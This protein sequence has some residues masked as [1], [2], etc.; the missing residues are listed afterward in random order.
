MKSFN[1]SLRLFST[2]FVSLLFAILANAQGPSQNLEGDVFLRTL[3]WGVSQSNLFYRDDGDYRPLA[4]SEGSLSGYH[5]YSGSR[6]FKVFRKVT[7]AETGADRYL[8]FLET[9]LVAGASQQIL[10]F[11]QSPTD[12]D[13]V[14][15]FAYDDSIE[16][17]G[18][19]A[20]FIGNFSPLDLAFQINDEERFGLKPGQSRIIEHNGDMHAVVQIAAYRGDQWEVEYRSSP[21]LWKGY[22]NYFF[23]RDMKGRSNVVNGIAPIILKE[24]VARARKAL[25]APDG[26]SETG[27]IEGRTVPFDPE[28]GF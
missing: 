1:P 26:A 5:P 15:V 22:R 16:H 12:R 6:N 18:E 17:M 20:V 9:T 14:R 11:F 3:G 21:R 28:A 24:N 13:L 4:L 2:A 27:R 10:V 19:Q 8:S 23:F 7:D 25:Q